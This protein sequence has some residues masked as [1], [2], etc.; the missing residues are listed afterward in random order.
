MEIDGY[1]TYLVQGTQVK[2]KL[3]AGGGF[4]QV[5]GP[6]GE[7]FTVL[8]RSFDKVA[9]EEKDKKVLTYEEFR[10]LLD[11]LN[12]EEI[13]MKRTIERM[14]MLHVEKREALTQR[15]PNQ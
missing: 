5:I 14:Q 2:A 9:V 1:K 11:E 10:V 8:K 3:T 13:R 12:D 7:E 15:R 4:Y 6:S